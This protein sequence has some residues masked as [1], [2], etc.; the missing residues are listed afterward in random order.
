[1]RSRSPISGARVA[2]IKAA[3]V[4]RLTL[5][6]RYD[7]GADTEVV[8]DDLLRPEAWDSLRTG[9]T[10]PFSIASDRGELERQADERPEIGERM[11][12]VDRWLDQHGARS[13]VSYGAGGG[14]PEL[15]LLR[16]APE[17]SLTL[18]DYAPA[19]VERLQALMPEAEVRRHDLLRDSPL[20]GDVHMF[21]RI[22]TELGNRDWR[23][24]FRR[25]ATRTVLVVAT[26]V[27]PAREIPRELLQAVRSRSGTRAGWTRTAGAFES[28][29][30]RTHRS[31]HLELGDLQG[32]ALEPR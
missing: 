4:V 20:E 3:A 19:T 8:G 24:V 14:V 22:D 7:F 21:H 31:T 2:A 30:R 5:P 16:I 10:G 29:W 12:L 28:L 32:W 1:M 25:F 11:R 23:G 18:T 27:M 26:E 15:W 13:V 9:T 17:R 6:H